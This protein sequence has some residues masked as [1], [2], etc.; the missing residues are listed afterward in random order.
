MKLSRLV[1]ALGV[2]VLLPV[3]AACGGSSSTSDD[4]ASPAAAAGPVGGGPFVGIEW[5]LTSAAVDSS[6]LPSFGLTIAFTDTDVSG[7]GGVN[8]FAG[9]FTSSPEGAMDFS[10][11]ASTMMAGPEDAMAAETAY[12]KALDTVT[13]YSVVDS[14]LVLYVD[15]QELL[16]YAQGGSTE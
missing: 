1:A 10:P 11:L 14:T 4:A 5:K 7:F 2:A 9:T 12:L 8:Q 13:G 16:T 6:D 15:E 3:L